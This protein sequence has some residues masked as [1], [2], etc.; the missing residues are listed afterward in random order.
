MFSS[1]IERQ[2]HDWR[3]ALFNPRHLIFNPCL[4][5]LRDLGLMDEAR[6]EWTEAY[7]LSGDPELAKDLARLGAKP[8]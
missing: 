7:R 3:Q 4:M 6:R 1:V 2:S 5:L 8:R